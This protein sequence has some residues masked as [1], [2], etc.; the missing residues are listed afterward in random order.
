M[1]EIELRRWVTPFYLAILHG[2]YAT[3]ILREAERERFNSAVTATLPTMTPAIAAQLISGHWREAITGSWFA[4][5][6]RYEECQHQ[7]GERLLASETCYAG[8]SHAFA[9][10]CFRNQ[11]SVDYLTAYLDTYLGRLDC[12][13]DQDWAMGALMWIDQTMNERHS[14]RFLEPNGPWD[15]FTADRL[16]DSDH[17]RSQDCFESIRDLIQYCR[18]H[19]GRP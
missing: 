17:W 1:S 10:A 6:Q 3:R 5:L 14:E 2:N 15:R 18:T 7:I 16:R 19:F 4:G 12:D 11:A 9:M 13:Y 8:Q